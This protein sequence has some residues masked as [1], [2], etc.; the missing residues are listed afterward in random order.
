MQVQVARIGKPHGIRGEVTVELFTDQPEARFA[1]GETLDIEE[2]STTSPVARIAPRGQLTVAGSRWNKKILVVRFEEVTSRNDAEVLR[3][4]RL[5][6]DS[7]EV[8]DDEGVY[9][10]DV[11]GLPVYLLADVPEEELPQGKGIGTVSGLQTMPT[12]D[13]LL[14]DLHNGG[15]AM[16]PFVE[17]LVPELDL[18]EKF[19]LIDPP[20][21]LLELDESEEG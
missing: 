4:T 5:V 17:E 6:F 12:Q 11:L 1:R 20:A 19:V 3:N 21:G 8:D 7:A 16:I 2:F 14:I 9:E 13:L 18:D 10:H 15:E